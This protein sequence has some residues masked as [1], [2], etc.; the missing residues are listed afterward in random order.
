MK[1]NKI[2]ISLALSSITLTIGTVIYNS[3][4]Y[5]TQALHW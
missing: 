5:G 4:V 3:I 1:T 2:A